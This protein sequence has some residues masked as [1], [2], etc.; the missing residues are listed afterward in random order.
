MEYASRI[1]ATNP[2]LTYELGSNDNDAYLLRG[3]LSFRKH[4]DGDEIAVTIDA[5]VEANQVVVVSD[6]CEGSGQVLAVGPAATIPWG[7]SP[8]VPDDLLGVWLVNFEQ[9]LRDSEAKVVMTALHL[10]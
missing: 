8:A 1:L 7:N 3:Y 2:A 10:S 4:C 6:I 9:F 5:R